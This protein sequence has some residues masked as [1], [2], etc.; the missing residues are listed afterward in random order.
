[1]TDADLIA[2][3]RKIVNHRPRPTR[4]DGG[5]RTERDLAKYDQIVGLLQ[6]NPPEQVGP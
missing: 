2:T 3:I 1:V 6:R 4:E 5:G